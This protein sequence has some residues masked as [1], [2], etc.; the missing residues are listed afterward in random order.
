MGIDGNNTLIILGP[1]KTLDLIEDGGIILTDNE[2][3]NNPDLIH[4]KENYFNDKSKYIREEPRLKINGKK[5]SNRLEISFYF[6][7]IPVDDYLKLLLNK[8]KDCW[9]KNQY[10]T[11]YGDCGMWIGQIENDVPNI[12]VIEWGEYTQEYYID[13]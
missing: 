11:E 6:R 3:N 1:S 5:T 4:L 7:N 8:Y 12:K 13:N 2:V 10:I 9:F